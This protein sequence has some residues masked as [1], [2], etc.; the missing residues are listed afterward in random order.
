VFTARHA[1]TASEALLL[2]A[3]AATCGAF[4][5]ARLRRWPSRAARAAA[6]IAGALVAS[7]LAAAPTTAWN[8]ISDAQAAHRLSTRAAERLG[9]EQN[10]VD[11]SLTDR[12]AKII[13]ERGTYALVLSN[14]VGADRALV[15]RLWSL[16]A[17]L[18]RIAVTDRRSADWIVSW[19]VTPNALGV[20]VD[21]VHVLGIRRGPGPPMYVSRVVR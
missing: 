1:L 4:L 9:V 16:S 12:A 14:R 15:F 20:R 18:P 19:G 3:V 7:S 6:A 8:I 10:G 5:A 13:P 11:T 17:M 21:D 2:A